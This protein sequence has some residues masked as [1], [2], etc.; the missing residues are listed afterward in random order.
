MPRSEFEKQNMLI[1]LPNKIPLFSQ[2]GKLV[3]DSEDQ[4]RVLTEQG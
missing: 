4:N 1:K 3:C 2:I